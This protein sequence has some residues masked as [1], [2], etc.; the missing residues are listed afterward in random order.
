MGCAKQARSTA[1]KAVTGTAPNSH[2]RTACKTKLFWEHKC[3][4]R[5][6]E[7]K[8][9][10]KQIYTQHE[11]LPSRFPPS[12][13]HISGRHRHVVT[14]GV[15]PASVS[16]HGLGDEVLMCQR[17]THRSHHFT[18]WTQGII[19]P[20]LYARI[21]G[22]HA[23]VLRQVTPRAKERNELKCLHR[24]NGIRGMCMHVKRCTHKDEKMTI[25]AAFDPG[26]V[27]FRTFW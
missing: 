25:V 14:L 6:L 26:S 10:H 5:C 1:A 21:G 9:P 24:Q 8:W 17:C 19:Q 23:S 13:D 18:L 3:S 15:L 16:R 2:M 7:P 20:A 11:H 27:K 12:H 4:R 22:L